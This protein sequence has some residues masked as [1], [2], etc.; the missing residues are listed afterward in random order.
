MLYLN[1]IISNSSTILH[2]G[3]SSSFM[4]HP[5]ILLESAQQV[6]AFVGTSNSDTLKPIQTP[7]IASNPLN[8]SVWQL[9]T[10]GAHGDGAASELFRNYAI[11]KLDYYPKINDVVASLD[12]E[13]QN[14]IIDINYERL[15]LIINLDSF[16]D[17]HVACTTSSLEE[18]R[19]NKKP[20]EAI[21]EFKSI[22]K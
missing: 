9:N 7:I 15:S 16:I 20:F 17:G 4:N 2:I 11:Y 10:I 18:I 8:D 13:N 22:T 6:Y 5:T 1:E 21:F 12:M 3:R 14:Q 19:Q